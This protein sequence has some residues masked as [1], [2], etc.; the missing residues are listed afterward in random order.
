MARYFKHSDSQKV[1]EVS[2]FQTFMVMFFG[3]LYLFLSEQ[4]KHL[5]IWIAIVGLTLTLQPQWTA[6]VCLGLQLFYMA[7][8]QKMLAARYLREGWVE[9][10]EEEARTSDVIG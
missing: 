3:P 2:S 7:F 1:E 6:P 5:M 9:I 10:S 4:L 8:I